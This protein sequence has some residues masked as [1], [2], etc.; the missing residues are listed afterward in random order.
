MSLSPSELSSP[1]SFFSEEAVWT[2]VPDDMP[3]DTVPDDTMPDDTVP[4]DIRVTSDD[5]VIC[6]CVCLCGCV[7]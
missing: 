4:N 7:I 3:D 6:V 2:T 1:D 5:Q